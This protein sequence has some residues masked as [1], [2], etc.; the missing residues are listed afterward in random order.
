MHPG[1]IAQVE[2]LPDAQ[3]AQELPPTADVTPLSS[4]EKQVKLERT[5]SAECLQCGHSAFSLALLIERSSSNLVSQSE[6]TYSYIGISLSPDLS[7][8]TRRDRSQYLKILVSKSEM[9]NK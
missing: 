5:R 3:L 1:Y 7:L 6:H 9:L 2:Q 4:E 8:R